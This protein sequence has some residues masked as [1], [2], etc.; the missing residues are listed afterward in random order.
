M[1]EVRRPEQIANAEC[2]TF[3]ESESVR[4][5][6]YPE[7]SMIACKQGQF[8]QWPFKLLCP[9]KVMNHLNGVVSRIAWSPRVR[10][11]GANP[12]AN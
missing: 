10:C 5:R 11:V 2:A 9:N 1:N 8:Y 7:A 4:V 6:R 3:S 12:S